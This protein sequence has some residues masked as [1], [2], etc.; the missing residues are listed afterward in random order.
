MLIIHVGF[1]GYCDDGMCPIPSL[2]S[3]APGL[4]ERASVLGE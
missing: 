4:S 3:T 2:S 1:V